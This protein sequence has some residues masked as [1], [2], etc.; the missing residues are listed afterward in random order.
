[1]DSC[2]QT[3][4]IGTGIENLM[5]AKKENISDSVMHV[6][7]KA[8]LLQELD[9]LRISIDPQNAE[10]TRPV[11]QKALKQYGFA[12]LDGIGF[13]EDRDTIAARLI[14]LSVTLGE[15]VPQS[16]RAERI[17]DIKDYSDTDEK[18]DRGYRSR[19]EL[20]PHSDPPTIILLHCLTP[21]RS[22]GE[23]HIVNVGAIHNAMMS[24][25]SDLSNVLFK[26]LPY[27]QPGN[28]G[29]IAEG[30]AADQRPVF[31][32]T[33]GVVSCVIYRPYIEK[34]AAA[35]N[36]PLSKEESAALDLF[37]RCASDPDL[38]LRFMLSPGETL[39]LH[40]RTVLH[41][42]TDY[43]DWL[44]RERRRHLLRAWIDAP[45]LLPVAGCHELGD[46]FADSVEFEAI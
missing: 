46:I 27:W 18:D 26:G 17:E 45:E 13:S 39:L 28:G 12:L 37:D 19:G 5:S 10:Q 4:G 6:C 29:S 1:L 2:Y 3:L 36:T 41:A 42:R 33:N 20:S 14:D 35:L 9:Q 44:E 38:S 7:W 34:A 8:D 43:E 31:T 24:I 40:N 30:P 11:V 25:D 23:N 22:G 16:P 15:L 32:S 21:A